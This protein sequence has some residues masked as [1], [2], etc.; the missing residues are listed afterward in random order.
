M[1]SESIIPFVILP[2]S[3]IHDRRVTERAIRVYGCL[4]T[5]KNR[6]TSRCDPHRDTIA[7]K[8]RCSVRSVSRCLTELRQAGWIS[9][10]Q[11]LNGQKYE[12]YTPDCNEKSLKRDT[13]GSRGR[14]TVGSPDAPHLFNEPEERTNQIPLSAADDN[15]KCVGEPAA[16]AA[17]G[18]FSRI[19]QEEKPKTASLCPASEKLVTELIAEHPEPGNPARAIDEVVKIFTAVDDPG[20]I[21]DMVRRHHALWLEYWA[22][23]T[24]NRFIPQLWRWLR[25]GEWKYPPAERKSAKHETARSESYADRVHR[26][27]RRSDEREYM[28][29][30]REGRWDELDER[31]E[32]PEVWRAKL[33][34]A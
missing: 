28:Q 9:S 34:V 19:D 4:L 20:E 13:V 17:A 22:T 10:K 23:L 5:Y 15:L 29:L 14:A 24:A 26:D 6:R 27:L 11:T 32:D 12:F 18:E 8:L 31:G 16:A 25:D 21:A 1:P 33:Q 30:A 7:K 2:V 3:L